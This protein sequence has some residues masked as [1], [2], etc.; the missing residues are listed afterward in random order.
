MHCGAETRIAALTA[1]IAGHAAR[2]EALLGTL[3]ALRTRLQ[4]Q[5]RDNFAGVE[6]AEQELHR[7][8]RVQSAQRRFGRPGVQI[9]LRLCDRLPLLESPVRLI[10]VTL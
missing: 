9:A 7:R 4:A 5:Q 3:D 2:E 1:R 6:V 8:A 10:G